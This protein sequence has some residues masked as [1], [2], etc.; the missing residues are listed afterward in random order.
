MGR[1]Q[2]EPL[3]EAPAGRRAPVWCRGCRR[4]LTDRTSRLRGWGP[5]CDPDARA[6]HERRDVDQDPILGL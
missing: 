1:Q 2:Q 3:P 4:P 5:E 6:G